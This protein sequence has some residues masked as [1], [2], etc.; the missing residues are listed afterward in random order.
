M[1]W[2]ISVPLIFMPFGLL[3]LGMAIH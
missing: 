1:G 3:W 2:L